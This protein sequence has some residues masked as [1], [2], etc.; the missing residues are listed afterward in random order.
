MKMERR[1]LR[2]Q[3]GVEELQAYIKFKQDY[4]P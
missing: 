3:E 2:L 1:F 4:R